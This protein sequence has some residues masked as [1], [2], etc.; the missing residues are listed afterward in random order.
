MVCLREELLVVMVTC[1][2][3]MVCL[4]EE[5]LV[6]T[7]HGLLQRVR[8]DGYVKADMTIEISIIPFSL[9]LQHSRGGCTR[10]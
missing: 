10:E 6:S 1:C 5:L 2:C 4:R 8:W 3:S 7:G 9:D